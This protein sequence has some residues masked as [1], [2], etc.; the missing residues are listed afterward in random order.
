MNDKVSPLQ[1]LIRLLKNEKVLVGNVYFYAFFN[2]LLNLSIPLGIQA[3]IN[4]IQSGTTSTSWIVLVVLVLVGIA[5]AGV[6]QI[7]QLSAT[8][9]IQQKIFS[10]ASIEFAFRLPRLSLKAL[11]DKYPPELVNRFF[12]IMTIQK[13]ISK[14]LFDF[15]IAFMQILFGLLLLA[16]YHPFF[17]ALGFVIITILVLFFVFTGKESLR[18]SL[19]ESK[20]KYKLVSW[21][22]EIARNLSTFKMAGNSKLPLS[23]TDELS[24]DYLDARK[25]HFA[26][27]VKQFV[28]MVGFK[29]LISG[30]LL[31]LGGILVFQE[32]MNIGQFVA[33]E[34][35]ILLIINSI[36]K[37][38]LSMETIY[39]VLTGLEK[40]GS[41]TD[42][43]LESQNGMETIEND[44]PA[45]KVQADN[46]TLV[47]PQHNEKRILNALNFTINAGEKVGITGSMGT[48]K[49]SLLHLLAGL[50]DDFEGKLLFND[51]PFKHLN[52]ES[53]RSVSSNN[54]REQEIFES[55]LLENISLGR[56]EITKEE[57]QEVIR[58]C[59]LETFV[60]DLPKGL[61]T[62]LPSSG[63]GLANSIVTR[64][65]MARCLVGNY[66]L[67]LIE[68]KWN[69]VQPSVV[70]QWGEH[71]CNANSATTLISTSNPAILEKMDRII[72]LSDGAIQK[73]GTFNEIKDVLPC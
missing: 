7:Y 66:Q 59:G 39:D 30:S 36:E 55:S 17:I 10:N 42:L 31:I 4:L 68:D 44:H 28:V 49:S 34:I 33:A 73:I 63:L 71:L 45:I 70:N 16:F 43:E 64:I 23:R 61:Q 50:Y 38:I 12:D 46:V 18:T 29:V 69:D 21:L 58:L 47:S 15:S 62:P 51:I 57:V 54:L 13:G 8:E 26:E 27:L 40:V 72:V 67:L 9:T 35:I 14:I 37:L 25:S 2:G 32:E 48:G 19:E 5:L 60:Q 53:L 3:I 52:L 20:Y 24:S 22:E 1:R 11:K 65:L 6:F 56:D 41:I